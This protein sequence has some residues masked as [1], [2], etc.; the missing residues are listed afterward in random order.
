ML[1]Q[2]L[3]LV[4]LAL[5]TKYMALSSFLKHKCSPCQHLAQCFGVCPH[6]LTGTKVFWS[7]NFPAGVWVIVT[8]PVSSVFSQ[9]IT[10]PLHSSHWLQ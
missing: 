4:L 2:D 7:R 8:L 5:V 9:Y 6:C 10:G 1:S 3:H